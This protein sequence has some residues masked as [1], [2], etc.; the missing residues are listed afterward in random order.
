MRLAASSNLSAN[1]VIWGAGSGDH[2]F[3]TLEHQVYGSAA[4]FSTANTLLQSNSTAFGPF[5]CS[6]DS[7]SP[8]VDQVGV[9]NDPAT[10]EPVARAVHVSGTH[11]CPAP[12]TDCTCSGGAIAAVR[13]D[14]Q[15]DFISNSLKEW[16]GKTFNLNAATATDGTQ[17][18]EAWGAKCKDDT[19]CKSG[20]VCSRAGAG[21]SGCSQ[22]G[23][24]GDCSCIYGQCLPFPSCQ[25]GMQN[26]TETDVD[27]GGGDCP[28]GCASGQ[29]CIINDDCQSLMCS[30]TT[31]L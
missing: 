26:G 13:I 12:H 28:N 29:N 1:V 5:T 6:G 2:P 9:A 22:C 20:E 8:I 15:M 31:C 4:P 10:S 19:W 24:P 17:Y 7:G 18:F 30:G 14:T 3:F 25:D 11:N 27:C 23:S 21:L 16:N